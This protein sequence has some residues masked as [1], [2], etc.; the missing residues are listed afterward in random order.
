MVIKK[1]HTYKIRADGKNDTGAPKKTLDILPKSWEKKVLALYYQG[2][3]DIEV[4]CMLNISRDLWYRW[5]KEEPHFSDTIKKGRDLCEAWWKGVGRTNLH[6]KQFS[7]VGWY[8]Q[9]KNRFGWKD[10]TEVENKNVELKLTEEETREYINE[11]K[12]KQSNGS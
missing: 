10:K 5:L 9:M 6:D 7:Y 12:K 8:M 11:L 3:S 4:M 1:K 2:G